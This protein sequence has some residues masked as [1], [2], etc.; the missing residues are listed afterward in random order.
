MGCPITH[1]PQDLP[2]IFT[3]DRPVPTEGEWSRLLQKVVQCECSY[4]HSTGIVGQSCNNCGAPI[5]R[6]QG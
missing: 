6:K 5:N 4:C 2:P 3:Y 1:L